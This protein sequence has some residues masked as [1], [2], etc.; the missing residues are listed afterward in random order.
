MLLSYDE[1]T[2][3]QFLALVYL[4]AGAP[5]PRSPC[6]SRRGTAAVVMGPLDCGALRRR[7]PSRGPFH[8]PLPG[9]APASGTCA[10]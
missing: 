10:T 8:G 2:R 6:L 1:E 4:P 7:G 5:A 9:S 3:G